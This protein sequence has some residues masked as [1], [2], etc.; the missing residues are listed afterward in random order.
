MIGKVFFANSDGGIFM[1]TQPEVVIDAIAQA[2]IIHRLLEKL[3]ACY[4]YPDVAGEIGSQL[5][6]HLEDGDYAGIFEGEFFALALTMHMQEVNHDEHLWVRWHAAA[7][8]E[9]DGPLRLNQKW[10]EDRQLEARLDN[11]GVHKLERL[12]GNVGYMDIHYFHRPAWGGDTTAA[13]MNFLAHTQA[14]IIDL[15]QC[16]GGYPGMISLV[17]SYLFGEEP[18]HLVSIYWRDEDITQQYW[19]LPYV[20]GTHFVDKPVYVLTSKVTF[21]AGEMFANVLQTR[22]RATVIGEKTDGGAHA[23]ASYRLHPHFEVFIPIG[24]T[25]NPLTGT[26]WEGCGVSPDISVPQ[27]QAFKVAY[28]QALESIQAG[29]G[30][31]PSG[32]DKA[33]A[34][35]TGRAL[36]GIE[37]P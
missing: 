2:D 19:T 36:E 12:P 24:R 6:K 8:P 26:N 25:I 14:L 21:S 11:Y 9:D 3:N 27:D 23:G 4:I 1:A 10:Q 30:E 32:P 28:K 17:C 5:Q 34:E 22:Q 35:E 33:L 31:S 18:V 16:T 37:S 29:L 13:A 7:L 20:P 15:R